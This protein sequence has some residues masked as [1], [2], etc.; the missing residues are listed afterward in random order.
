MATGMDGMKSRVEMTWIWR[1]FSEMKG[2]DI[3]NSILVMRIQ[4]SG[5]PLLAIC[6]TE[7]LGY[8]SYGSVSYAC[9]SMDVNREPKMTGS[10]TA[11]EDRMDLTLNWSHHR[12]AWWR[13]KLPEIWVFGNLRVRI[14]LLSIFIMEAI[15]GWRCDPQ[16]TIY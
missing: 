11:V 3:T 8:N 16:G 15:F 6:I 9:L 13:I 2:W 5:C 10:S 1:S 4:S 12:A 14:N 7:H